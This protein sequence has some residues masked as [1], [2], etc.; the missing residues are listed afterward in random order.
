MA[1]TAS[2]A[3]NGGTQVATLGPLFENS[4]PISVRGNL[5][6]PLLPHHLALPE[7]D[8]DKALLYPEGLGS[9]PHRCPSPSCLGSLHWLSKGSPLLLE[10]VSAWIPA[11]TSCH[12]AV[13]K[14]QGDLGLPWWLSS[15]EYACNAGDLGS[16]PGP[17]R[18]PGEDN[19]YPLQYSCLENSVDSGACRVPAHGITKSQK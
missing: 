9:I 11:G 12:V 6:G 1:G 18:F 13:R 4:L 19:G 16:I 10:L 15:K 3:Q 7:C 14:M 17:G 5:P 2:H 8:H